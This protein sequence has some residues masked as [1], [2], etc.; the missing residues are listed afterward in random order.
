MRVCPFSKKKPFSMLHLCVQLRY[1]LLK[2]YGCREKQT[3]QVYPAQRSKKHI[4]FLKKLNFC[5]RTD[6]QEE[7]LFLCIIILFTRLGICEIW[8]NGRLS[9]QSVLSAAFSCACRSIWYPTTVV[10]NCCLSSLNPPFIDNNLPSLFWRR[11]FSSSACC[12]SICDERA[13]G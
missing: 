2:H 5:C 12:A 13:L 1:S 10:R 4:A 7:K 11:A 3:R 8:K 6:D 9:C